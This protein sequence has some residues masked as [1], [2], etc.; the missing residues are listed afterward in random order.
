MHHDIDAVIATY[1]PFYN[2][3]WEN[4]SKFMYDV[5]MYI[6]EMYRHDDNI[7]FRFSL[8]FIHV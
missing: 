5:Y 2:N 6:A 8:I 3:P 7:F 1:S 4:H